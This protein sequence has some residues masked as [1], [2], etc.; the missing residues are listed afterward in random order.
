[1]VPFRETLTFAPS[2]V[3]QKTALPIGTIEKVSFDKC[4]DVQLRTI[5]MPPA[6]RQFL[7]DE[8]N[9]ILEIEAEKNTDRATELIQRLKEICKNDDS[10]L[11]IDV[12]WDAI[13]DR[14]VSFGPKASVPN[15]LCLGL[16]LDTALWKDFDNQEKIE[17]HSSLVLGFQMGCSAG[18]LCAEPLAGVILL[19]QRYQVDSSLS[20]QPIA[21]PGQVVSIFKDTIK[22]GFM[23]WSPRLML[24]MYSCEIQT[25]P[26]Y[27]GSTNEVL[28]RRRGKIIAED[29]KDGT[30]LFTISAILPIV[31]SFGFVE[32]IRTNTS[33]VAQPQLLFHGF[34]VLDQDPFWVPSTEEELEDLGEKADRDNVAKKYMEAVRVRK[35]MAIEK[36]LADPEKQRNLKSK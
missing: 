13:L 29:V 22:Q 20:D 35:G 23:H 4:I 30:M 10:V 26:M 28:S 27:L 16:G 5:P 15:L 34:E 14:I 8:Q 1:L 9:T 31:E 11:D 18:P 2:Q 25:D 17:Y 12:D 33:G 24:A 6:L 19:V 21:I 3:T 32:E 36:R 7:F